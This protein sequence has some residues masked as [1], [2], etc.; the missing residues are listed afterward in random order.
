MLYALYRCRGDHKAKRKLFGIQNYYQDL[1]RLDFRAPGL[2]GEERRKIRWASN[3]FS[4]GID[5]S[6]G[7][8]RAAAP[9]HHGL[10]GG[11]AS[12]FEGFTGE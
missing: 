9:D 5:G 2:T 11:T 12:A 7:F 10:A 6:S 3:S 4:G 1:R 8:D